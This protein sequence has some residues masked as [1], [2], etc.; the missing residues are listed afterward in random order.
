MADTGS[1]NSPE[2]K[3]GLHKRFP[4]AGYWFGMLPTHPG[5]NLETTSAR[6]P[7]PRHN[8]AQDDATATASTVVPEGDC[9]L[10]LFV[11]LLMQISS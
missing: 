5:I 9:D 11:N 3:P 10:A 6:A 7:S 1:D 4:R 8:A 2:L